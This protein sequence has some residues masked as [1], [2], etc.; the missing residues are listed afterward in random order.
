MPTILLVRHAQASY[1]GPDYDVLS[2][3]A[4]RQIAALAAALEDRGLRGAR[5]VSGSLRRQRETATLGEDHADVASDAR[6]DEYDADAIF[7]AHGDAGLSLSGR[8]GAQQPSP[9]AFQAA[10]DAALA[11]WV[12]AQ[13]GWA[14]FRD[15]AVA[16][17]REL[18]GQ[19][20][21]GETALAFSSAGTIAAVCAAL[22]G[23]DAAFVALNRV[24]VN[25]AITRVAAGASGL[26]LVSFNGYEHLDPALVTLR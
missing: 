21:K 1:G 8:A 18:G 9:K 25:T 14:A 5:R 7:A 10:L 19:L 22:L 26:T 15:D 2:P 3:L 6:L 12:A 11:E 16:A 24:Q 17:V 4:A 13:D 23:A 20:G